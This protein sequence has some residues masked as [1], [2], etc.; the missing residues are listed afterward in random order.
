[1]FVYKP[2]LAVGNDGAAHSPFLE[3]VTIFAVAFFFLKVLGF[4]QILLKYNQILGKLRVLKNTNPIQ[5]FLP[6][7][8]GMRVIRGISQHTVS[9][10]MLGNTAGK[11]VGKYSQEIL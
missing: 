10:S 6:F 2:Y 5:P 4:V 3:P 1:M 8:V 9:N 11:T 7:K